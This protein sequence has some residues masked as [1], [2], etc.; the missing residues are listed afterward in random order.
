L[1]TR[2]IKPVIM[3]W[4]AIIRPFNSSI[5]RLL[6]FHAFRLRP[7]LQWADMEEAMSA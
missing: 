6:P 1:A 4:Q 2:A 5:R 3:I 7:D